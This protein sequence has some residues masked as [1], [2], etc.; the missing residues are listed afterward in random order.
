MKN[1]RTIA[2]P[3][4]MAKARSGK[5]PL[6][7]DP[8]LLQAAEDAVLRLG[9]EYGVWAQ[10]EL[11]ELAASAAALRAGEVEPGVGISDIARRALDIKGQAGAYGFEL[12]TSI[13]DLLMHHA[14]NLIDP[15]AR[16]HEIIVAHIDAMQAVLREKVKGHGGALGAEIVA[17]LEALVGRSER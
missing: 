1:A 9:D 16:D 14:E 7:I 15:T 3:D 11:E 6:R 12:I 4:G 2:P 17:G 5:G 10:E 8:A 13:A